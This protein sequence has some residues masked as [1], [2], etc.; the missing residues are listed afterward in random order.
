[1]TTKIVME[2]RLKLPD[3]SQVKIRSIYGIRI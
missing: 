3:L 1:M 2:L